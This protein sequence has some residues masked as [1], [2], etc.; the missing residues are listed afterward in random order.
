[1]GHTSDTLFEA[2]DA[3]NPALLSMGARCDYGIDLQPD[4]FDV[5]WHCDN[6]SY[7]TRDELRAAVADSDKLTLLVR[8]MGDFGGVVVKTVWDVVDTKCLINPDE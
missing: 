3:K 1:M 8:R 7:F 6:Q 5:Y 4:L 2:L